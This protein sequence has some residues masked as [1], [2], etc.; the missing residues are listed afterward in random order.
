MAFIPLN[1]RASA[2]SNGSTGANTYPLKRGKLGEQRDFLQPITD[3]TV[4]PP[5]YI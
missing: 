4:N 3:Q 2:A 5:S 1:G